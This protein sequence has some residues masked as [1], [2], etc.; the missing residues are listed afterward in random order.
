[1]CNPVLLLLL[2]LALLLTSPSLL[3]EL[4]PI[5]TGRTTYPL[6]A[7]VAGREGSVKLEAVI[8]ETGQIGALR[9]ISG[10]QEF[11]EAALQAVRQWRYR[12]YLNRGVPTKVRTTITVNF[13]FKDRADKA[14]SMAEAQAELAKIAT[15]PTAQPATPAA[16][17][18]Q[19]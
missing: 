14:K 8:D 7:K 13:R 11:Q 16:T 2:V 4:A 15:V 10:P 19:N 5:S 17:P 3:A 9:V 18:P 6:E 12:P 1:M